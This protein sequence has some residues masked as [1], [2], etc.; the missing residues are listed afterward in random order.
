MP[1]ARIVEAVDIGPD[2]GCSVA[3]G[4]VNGAPDQ[5]RF[6]GLEYSFDHGVVLAI[7]LPRHGNDEAMLFQ[8]FLII[9]LAILA[10][11]I[12]VMDYPFGR[13]PNGNGACQGRQ[14]QI[15]LGPITDRP[16]D[17]AA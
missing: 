14:S 6:D 11:P 17:D 3:A 2:L 1:A 5:F 8:E 12:G 16:A 13:T 10:A 4:F 15:L 9:V 7:A